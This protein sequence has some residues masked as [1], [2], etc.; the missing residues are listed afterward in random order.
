MKTKRMM[1][2]IDKEKCTGCGLCVPACEEGALQIVDGKAKLVSEIYCDGLGACLGECPEGAL[3]VEERMVDDFDPEAVKELLQEQG[4][5]IPD[6]MPE[7]ESLRLDGSARSG[8]PKSGCPGAVLKTM[9]PC[10]QANVPKASAAEG[11]NLS[12]WPVQLRLVPSSA[13]FLRGADLLLTADCVPVA[14]P[15]YHADYLAGKI[16]LMGCPKFDNAMEYV[17]KLAE[18]VRENELGSITI[19]EMEVPCCSSMSAILSQAMQ[20]AGQEVKTE[21]IIVSLK[22]QVLSREQIAG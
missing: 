10:Q 18:I 19:M 17:Q 20:Q 1:I 12:H 5:D 7:P 21:R 15:G 4:R 2:N 13:P 22:G 8:P 11:S 6:H 14:L 16:V 3:T 9:S